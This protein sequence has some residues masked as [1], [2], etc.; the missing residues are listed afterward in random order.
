[1]T[2]T[3]ADHL[4]RLDDWRN[5]VLELKLKPFVKMA[6]Y[7]GKHTGRVIHDSSVIDGRWKVKTVD[8]WEDCSEVLHGN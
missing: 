4:K 1:M 6:I 8:G 3:R 5:V 7:V 2:Y